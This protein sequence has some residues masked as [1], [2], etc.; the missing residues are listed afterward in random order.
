MTAMA[1][2]FGH[3]RLSQKRRARLFREYVPWAIK[4][5]SSAQSLITVYWEKRWEQDVGEL[6]KELGIWNPPEARW[7]KP[8][9]E[10]QELTE[11]RRRQA[12]AQLKQQQ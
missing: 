11:K 12:E 3:L 1:A 7:S 9:S 4:C 5:G 6:K 10:A 8:L 2:A